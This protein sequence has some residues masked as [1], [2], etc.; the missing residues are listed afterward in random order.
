MIGISSGEDRIP[1]WLA[2]KKALKGSIEL[3]KTGELLVVR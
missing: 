2:S 3:L 1:E